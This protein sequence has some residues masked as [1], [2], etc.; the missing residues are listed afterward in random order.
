ML[1]AQV[2]RPEIRPLL[3]AN[4][5]GI[6]LLAGESVFA[7]VLRGIM[8]FDSQKSYHRLLQCVLCGL[9]LLL[10]AHVVRGGVC[11]RALITSLMTANK[12]RR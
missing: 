4:A 6:R 12:N 10:Y 1:A 8:S 5:V 2:P 11:S 9:L 3:L 7:A